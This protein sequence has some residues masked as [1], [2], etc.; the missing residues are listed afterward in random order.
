MQT[1][2]TSVDYS[3]QRARDL[4][5]KTEG[6]SSLNEARTNNCLLTYRGNE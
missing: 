3:K 5:Q 2:E 4:S 1:V 6:A